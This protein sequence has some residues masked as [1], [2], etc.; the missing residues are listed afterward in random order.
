M[1]DKRRIV[2]PSHPPTLAPWGAALSE[3]VQRR[4]GGL[5]RDP[6]LVFIAKAD[7]SVEVLIGERQKMLAALIGDGRIDAVGAAL[8]KDKAP[9]GFVWIVVDLG[10]DLVCTALHP[11]DVSLLERTLS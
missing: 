2:A 5:G 9:V 4:L 7:A 10:N 3:A 8:L 11:V 6:V 1:C